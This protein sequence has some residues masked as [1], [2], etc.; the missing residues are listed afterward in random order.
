[1]HAPTADFSLVHGAVHAAKEL[2]KPVLKSMAMR[3]EWPWRSSSVTTQF[4]TIT[5]KPND[6]AWIAESL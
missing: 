2:G 5:L 6:A 1:M 3:F 4:P